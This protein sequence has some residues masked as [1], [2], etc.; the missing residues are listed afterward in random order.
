MNSLEYID[1]IWKS[2]KGEEKSCLRIT[3]YLEK[4]KKI[5]KVELP[6][7]IAK[8]YLRSKSSQNAVKKHH[9]FLLLSGHRYWTAALFIVLP[10]AGLKNVLSL[11]IYQWLRRPRFKG[12][13][14]TG[15][16]FSVSEVPDK[17][18]QQLK[19]RV[20]YSKEIEEQGTFDNDQKPHIALYKRNWFHLYKKTTPIDS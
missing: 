5:I 16:I 4:R 12:T 8:R 7:Y 15:K 13:A 20:A 2:L 18:V 14:L 1:G 9:Q 10:F 6:F 3:V 11:S 19:G 17:N